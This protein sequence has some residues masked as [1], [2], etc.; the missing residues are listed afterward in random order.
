MASAA[1]LLEKCGK[2][3]FAGWDYIVLLYQ[4]RSKIV[5]ESRLMTRPLAG[6]VIRSDI[7]RS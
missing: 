2:G 4:Q 6:T 3:K 7:H 5:C 1:E